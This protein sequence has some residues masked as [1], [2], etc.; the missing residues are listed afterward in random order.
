MLFTQHRL[1]YW[2]TNPVTTPPQSVPHRGWTDGV[3]QQPHPTSSQA[4]RRKHSIS[5]CHTKQRSVLPLRR[6][7]GTSWSR[8]IL[9][10]PTFSI[11]APHILYRGNG[12]SQLRRYCSIGNTTILFQTNYLVSLGNTCPSHFG[13]WYVVPLQTV[14]LQT[15]FQDS[16]VVSL[17]RSAR[18]WQSAKACQFRYILKVEHF[19]WYIAEAGI[20]HDSLSCRKIKLNKEADYFIQPCTSTCTITK[21]PTSFGPK[22]HQCNILIAHYDGYL[23]FIEC[24]WTW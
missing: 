23:S 9:H 3:T 14:P 13:P 15:W 6:L 20:G 1:S 12:D 17:F 11:S 2:A 22:Y 19:I 4:R 18:P 16:Q 10:W 21:T 7:S 8:A 24:L 5:S